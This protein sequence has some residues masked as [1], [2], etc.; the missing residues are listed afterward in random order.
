MDDAPAETAPVDDVLDRALR[1][2]DDCAVPQT[3]NRQQA[4]EAR[5]FAFVPGAQWE[6]E[7]GDQWV[8]RIRLSINKVGRLIRRVETDYRANRIMP[9][10]KPS[11]GASDEDTAETLNGMYRA[12]FTHFKTQQAVDNAVIE[13]LGG[14]MGAYRLLNA[15]AD[16]HDP[17]NDHQRVNP[18]A[19]ITDAD[20]CVYFDANSKLYDKSDARF[21]FVVTEWSKDA[22]EE[23]WPDAASDWPDPHHDWQYEWFEPDVVRVAEYYEREERRETLYVFTHPLLKKAE[24]FWANELADEQRAELVQSGYTMQTQRRKRFVVR[25]WV[26]SGGDV[27]E[28]PTRVAGGRIPIVPVYGQR[29]FVDGQ[30]RFKGITQDRMDAQ[31]VYNASV[32]RQGETAASSSES[33]PIV[34]PEQ[35]EGAIADIWARKAIDRPAFLPLNPLYN[36]DGSIAQA[37][38]IGMLQ[39]AQPSPADANLLQIANQDLMEDDQDSAEKVKANV[40]AEAMDIAAARVDAKSG[41]YLANIRQSI[42]C[43]GEIY[44]GMVAECCSEPGREVETQDQDGGDGKAVLFEQYTDGTGTPRVRNDFSQGKYKCIASVSEATATRRDK[45]VRQSLNMAEVAMKAGDQELAR[46][47]LLTAAANTDGEGI[48]DLKAYVRKLGLNIGLFA[49]NEDEQKQMEQAAQTPD[50]NSEAM[51][52]QAAALKASAEKDSALA[53][54]AVADTALS[55][56]KTVETLMKANQPIPPPANDGPM[57]RRGNDFAGATLQ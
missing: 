26:L 22:F 24:R 36:Q 55:E 53:G 17:E 32:S 7:Y 44:M 11:G 12:D 1:R 23:K 4:L 29:W 15:Y 34:A 35:V 38:P 13:A 21:A 14:G 33:V 30:E 9:D 54:K 45:T 37:G 31:R 28:G 42:Q 39:P 47:S 20:Q 18:G 48:D 56:A 27:L 16:E 50:P 52:A 43:G 51:M 8:N 46:A 10:F 25:K 41:I 3:E 6:G 19:I 49:P 2:F 40:S 57:I 5:R